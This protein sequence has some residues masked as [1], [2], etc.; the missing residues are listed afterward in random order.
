[1]SYPF[2]GLGNVDCDRDVVH[3]DNELIKIYIF[4]KIMG[5]YTLYAY[6]CLRLGNRHVVIN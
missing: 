2:I 4:I 6:T 3:L 5:R 1:M